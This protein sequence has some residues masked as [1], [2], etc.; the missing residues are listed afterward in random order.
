MAT[1]LICISATIYKSVLGSKVLLNT[2]Q[3]SHESLPLLWKTSAFTSSR[4][5]L[6]FAVMTALCH[7]TSFS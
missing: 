4:Q 7:A 5:S 3:I 2:P 1:L 6:C